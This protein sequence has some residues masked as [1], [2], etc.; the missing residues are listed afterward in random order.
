MI[1]PHCQK[2]IPDSTVAKHLAAKGGSKS[3]RTITQDEQRRMQSLRGTIKG[4]WSTRSKLMKSAR[5]ILDLAQAKSKVLSESEIKR[6]EAIEKKIDTI[7]KKIAA[8]MQSMKTE[9]EKYEQGKLQR[10]HPASA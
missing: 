7:D 8:E 4:M 3:K 9:L 2:D 5:F 6:L 10:K 1:C